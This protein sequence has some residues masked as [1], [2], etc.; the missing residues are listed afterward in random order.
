MSGCQGAWGVDLRCPLPDGHSEPCA[1]E[2]D[3]G[4]SEAFRDSLAA[5]GGTLHTTDKTALLAWLDSDECKAWEEAD[6][7][8]QPAGHDC[9]AGRWVPVPRASCTDCRRADKMGSLGYH[10]CPCGRY[11]Q[12][13]QGLCPCGRQR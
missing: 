5:L 2:P 4:S 3:K 6:P 8:D 12:E 11:S 9:E 13:T 1:P 10:V 7:L